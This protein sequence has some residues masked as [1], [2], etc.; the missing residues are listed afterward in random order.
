MSLCILILSTSM[1]VV[2]VCVC[3]CVRVCVRVCVCVCVCPSVC[4]SVCVCV[5]FVGCASRCNMCCYDVVLGGV[6]VC[7]CVCGREG[8]EF[9]MQQG[10]TVCT[11]TDQHWLSL[12]LWGQRN[13]ALKKTT[14]DI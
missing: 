8:G 10:Y 3:V 2:C 12:Q 13:I 1:Y 5:W 14:G 7:V 4:V 9:Y 6:C 11:I